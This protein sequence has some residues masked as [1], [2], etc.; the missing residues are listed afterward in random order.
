MVYFIGLSPRFESADE[1]QS[2]EYKVAIF[3]DRLA[4]SQSIFG[5]EKGTLYGLRTPVPIF[6][7]EYGFIGWGFACWHKR[8]AVIS[9]D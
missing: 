6:D 4:R 8:L 3:R 9:E 5:V 1:K 2:S 7:V